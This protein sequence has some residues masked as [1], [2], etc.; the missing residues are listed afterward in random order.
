MLYIYTRMAIAASQMLL[1]PART[2]ALIIS[3]MVKG[4]KVNIMQETCP[5]WK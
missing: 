1:L 2:G 4:A 3:L 5:I